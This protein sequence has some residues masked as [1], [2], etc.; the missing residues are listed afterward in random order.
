MDFQNIMIFTAWH[1]LF[2]A[3]F[4]TGYGKVKNEVYEPIRS[5]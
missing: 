5:R 3:F 2:N 4:S 1:E